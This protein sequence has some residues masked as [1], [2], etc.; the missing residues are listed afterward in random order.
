MYTNISTYFN[1]REIIQS[2]GGLQMKKSIYSTNGIE[3]I[4]DAVKVSDGAPTVNTRGNVGDIITDSNSGVLYY[5]SNAD[6]GVYTW[7]KYGDFDSGIKI[8]A[9]GLD[10]YAGIGTLVAGVATINA[11]NISSTDLIFIQRK[12]PNAS[13]GLG[14]LTYEITDG[15]SF[16]VRS[17]SN[18]NTAETTDL[19]S[20]SYMI[21][22]TV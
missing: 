6:A 11:T 8:K 5:L 12:D 2:R 14:L 4:N 16:V 13:T 15:I 20:F 3:Y 9:G 7:I 18:T 1:V 17:L 21:V 10:D 19:S 22:K